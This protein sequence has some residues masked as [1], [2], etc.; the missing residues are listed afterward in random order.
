MT[1][2]QAVGTGL[3]AL[4][5]GAGLNAQS[6]TVKEAAGP[7]QVK[8]EQLTGEVVL[9]EGNML[10]ARMPNGVY[11]VFHLRPGQPFTIDGQTRTINELKP[12]TKLTATAVT[13][14]RP[15]N[16][17]TTQVIDGTVWYVQGNYVIL[18]L[19]SGENREY[20]VPEG[21]A[22]TV[23]GKPATVKELR[24]GMKV[25]A[26]KI[27]EEPLTEIQEKTTIVG[28]APK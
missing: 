28:Q 19:V 27:V 11:R 26:T 5:M 16:L 20:N 10:L 17:R 13:T 21:M 23:S 9:T 22:F 4:A 3:L 7:A 6:S 24:K 8:V 25:S 18:T 1:F 12:G 14:T 15:L 2:T